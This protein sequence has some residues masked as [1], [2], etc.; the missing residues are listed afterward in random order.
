MAEQSN[1]LNNGPSS[2]AGDQELVEAAHAVRA[3]AYAPYSE[4]PVGAAVRDAQGRIHVGANVENASLGLSI[5]AER[6]AIARAA[7]EGARVIVAVAVVAGHGEPASPCGACRQVLAEFGPDMRVLL[8]TEDG[9]QRQYT[10]GELLA[11][12]FL[13]FRNTKDST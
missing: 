2:E 1:N 5:C 13:D 10:L 8:A 12:P 6:N 3:N 9:A 4:F 11:H 7:A